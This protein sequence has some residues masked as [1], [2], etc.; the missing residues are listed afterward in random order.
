MKKPDLV[1]VVT[2]LAIIVVTYPLL[3][4]AGIGHPRE[5]GK[6]ETKT[7]LVAIIAALKAYH[8]EYDKWPDFTGNGLFLD[9]ERQARLMRVLCAKD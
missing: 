4:P 3:F 1:Q 8:T 7:A 5:R 6:S 2:I 9:E